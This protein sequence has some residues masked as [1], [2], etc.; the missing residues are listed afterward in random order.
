ML[1]DFRDDSE[2]PDYIIKL[3]FMADVRD[4]CEQPGVPNK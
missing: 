3:F 4:D 2:Q 1:T